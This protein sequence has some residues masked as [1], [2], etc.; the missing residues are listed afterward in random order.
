MLSPADLSP[1]NPRSYAHRHEVE[2]MDALWAR[3]FDVVAMAERW[4]GGV[5]RVSRRPGIGERLAL[6]GC[7]T[8]ESESSVEIESQPTLHEKASSEPVSDPSEMAL[9]SPPPALAPPPPCPDPPPQ[10]PTLEEGPFWFGPPLVARYSRGAPYTLQRCRA[11]QALSDL[12]RAP[13]SNRHFR[14]E[15][16]SLVS[17]TLL[18]QLGLD[19]PPAVTLAA[20]VPWGL[21]LAQ[22][23]H[24]GASRA[25]D[26]LALV[27][28]A[29][30]ESTAL[31]F[32]FVRD[33]DTSSLADAKTALLVSMRA[34]LALL[35]RLYAHA[36]GA[37]PP[38]DSAG[39]SFGLLQNGEAWE[40]FMMHCSPARAGPYNVTRLWHG[41]MDVASDVVAFQTLCGNILASVDER[42]AFAAGC[43]RGAYRQRAGRGIPGISDD[44]APGAMSASASAPT[45]SSSCPAFHLGL[46][47]AGELTVEDRYARISA[48]VESAR[49]EV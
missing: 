35:A 43:L 46:Y 7:N 42:I 9:D 16:N 3:P 44:N 14:L 10:P 39:Q 28:G 38:P 5:E 26:V 17:T 33:A 25:D 11:R 48:W 45:P 37:S 13:F 24:D 2:A 30:D 22:W 12:L 40:L 15:E 29:E 36:R 41:R 8:E 18:A 21:V 47:R 49:L 19:L 27:R 4:A 31:P 1:A 6:R 23:G 20:G 32:F 34:A